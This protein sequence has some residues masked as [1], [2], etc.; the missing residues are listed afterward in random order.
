M[1]VLDIAVNRL[2]RLAAMARLPIQPSGHLPIAYKLALVITLLTVS[3]MGLLGLVIIGNQSHL[4]DKQAEEYGNALTSQLAKSAIEPLLAKDNLALEL[5]TTNLLDNEGIEG[6]AIYSD[7]Y[8]LLAGGGML[9]TIAARYNNRPVNWFSQQ[10]GKMPL[11]SFSSTLQFRDL[12]IGYAV[13]T[14]DRSLLEQARKMTVSTISTI[15]LFMVVIGIISAFVLGQRL[16]RPIHQLLDGS[17]EISSGNYHFRFSE[18]R[19]DELGLL[20][21]SFND[22]T[23]GL[24][25][26]EQ[27]EQTFSRYVSPKVAKELLNDLEQVQ[28]GGHHVRASV[29]F[30]DIVGFT[31]LSE[32]MRPDEVN[33]LLNDYFT[34]IDQAAH[35]C[36]GHVDK[37]MGDCAM[38]LFGVP[39]HDEDHCYH[40]VSC[41]VLI[42]QQLRELNEQRSQQ[43]LVTA[44]FRIGVNSGTMLAGNM[45]SK[46][47]M[48]Y[49]VVGDAVNLAS[50][51]S[52]V[53]P[54]GEII[55][56]ETMHDDQKLENHFTTQRA[57]TIRLRGKSQPVLTYN[58]LGLKEGE[59]MESILQLGQHEIS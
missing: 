17:H 54:P 9:P 35:R 49:T 18:R 2:R 43:G 51:L 4:L 38:L 27:V 22:M 55:I 41:A 23:A 29:L 25:R 14:F 40:A 28:L 56:T 37:Y 57:D 7:E 32:K 52:S 45:G 33:S 24:L 47:R 16:T 15:T 5:L 36:H 53:A 1:G 58:V 48:E 20:M 42:Q 31:R 44:E 13:L 8:Q 46:Q 30:A 21:R 10:N 59:S 39:E 3:G 50:R 6:A 34:L 19:N 26:K 11:L 12:T